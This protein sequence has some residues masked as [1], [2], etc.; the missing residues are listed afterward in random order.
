[1]HLK[2]KYDGPVSNFAF[3]FNLCRYTKAGGGGGGGGKGGGGSAKPSGAPKHSNENRLKRETA[4]LCPME[5]RNDLPM[6]P[7]D[8]KLL[9]GRGLHSSSF[10]LNLSHF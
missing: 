6:V 4:F 1:M 2:L 9:P 5:F 3:K 10:Q 7:V 8:W